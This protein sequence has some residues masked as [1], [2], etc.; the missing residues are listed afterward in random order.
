MKSLVRVP[1][2]V[3]VCVYVC[4][5]AFACRVCVCICVHACLCVAQENVMREFVVP[6]D[7]EDE[8]LKAERDDA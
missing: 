3:H 4:A 7:Q 8:A 1:V 2:G 6:L 5:C